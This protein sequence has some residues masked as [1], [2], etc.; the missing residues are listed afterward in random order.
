M[1]NVV[2]QSETSILFNSAKLIRVPLDGGR[3]GVGFRLENGENIHEI[4]LTYDNQSVTGMISSTSPVLISEFL[5][6]KRR[7]V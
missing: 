2:K 6:N 1:S 3:M 5:N 4:V 7:M